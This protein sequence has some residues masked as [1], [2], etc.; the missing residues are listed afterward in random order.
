[1]NQK[2][3]RKK[4]KKSSN[5][6]PN[7]KL[8]NIF[9]IIFL[10][11]FLATIASYFTIKSKDS[12]KDIPNDSKIKIEAPTEIK[13]DIIS[14]KTNEIKEFKEQSPHE[15]FEEKFEIH[16]DDKF[17]EYTKELEKVILEKIDNEDSINKENEI[18]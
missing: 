7:R 11:A 4:S 6:S 5:F 14:S 9:L 17:E 1:M 10:I 2:K 15:F 18:I 16:E 8:I 3:P 12:I 13:K